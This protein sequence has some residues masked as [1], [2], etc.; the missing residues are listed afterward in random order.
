MSSEF[1]PVLDH[2]VIN[3]AGNLDPAADL[4]GRL[5]FRLTERGHH[6]LGSSNNLAIFRSNYLELLGYLPERAQQRADLWA[7]PLG[8]TGLVFR[9][10]DPEAVFHAVQASGVPVL[11]PVQFSRP[12]ALPDGTQDARFAVIRLGADVIENGRVFFCHHYTP[13]LVWRP[14]WQDHPNGVTDITEF[15]LVSPDPAATGAV[16][17]R[18]FG[19]GLLRREGDRVSFDAGTATVTVLTPAAAA[20]RFGDALPALP[21]DGSARM[22][23]LVLG[24]ASVAAAAAALDQG[25]IP[26]RPFEGGHLVA[27]AEAANVALA[28]TA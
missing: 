1:R 9:S 26:H 10:H 18:I 5:G 15:V 25:G 22:V 6:T 27:A 3:V 7:H 20:A 2:V 12:V 21:E 4:Y 17:D 14:E 19:G 28:F 24:T 11:D 13:E 8:L 23:A 16:Y